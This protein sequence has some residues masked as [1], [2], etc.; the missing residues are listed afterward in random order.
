MVN[1]QL[2]AVYHKLQLIR[3]IYGAKNLLEVKK[4]EGLSRFGFLPFLFFPLFFPVFLF[5]FFFLFKHH[6]FHLQTEVGIK[7]AS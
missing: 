5:P 7:R 3:I 2:A 6:S 4:W 1:Q